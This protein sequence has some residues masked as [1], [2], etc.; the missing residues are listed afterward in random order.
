[1][2]VWLAGLLALAA[3]SVPAWAQD[4]KDKIAADIVPEAIWDGRKIA[5]FKA[6][7]NPPMV[8]ASE[9]DFLDDDEYVLGV[10]VGKESRA[11]PTRFTWWHHFINDQI[12]DT[13]Y[14]VS[15]CSVCNTGIRFDRR[16]NGKTLLFDFYGLYNGVVIMC[17]RE[18][19]SVFLQVA[20]RAIKGPM[21]GTTLKTQPL[22]DTTW[23]EWKKLHPNTLVMTPENDFKKFY[24]D[25][26]MGNEPRG[27]ARFPAP[28]F[29]PTMTRGDKRIP[30]FDKV[31][32]VH[33]SDTSQGKDPAK[34]V[35]R[36]YP[37]KTLQ[38][39]GGVLTDDAEGK[40]VVVFFDPF[41]VSAAAFERKLDGKPLTFEARPFGD[42]IGWFD[43]ET[44]SRWTVEGDAVEGPLAGKRL[45][46]LESH[47]S[48]WYGWAAYF[49]KTSIY[50]RNDAAQ[51]GN[52]FDDK[53][54][55]QGK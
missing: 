35:S 52:P 4:G 44:G 7:D 20:G 10:T 54:L 45:P 21:T 5:P 40:Q 48:Q 28:F 50:G 15:Y 42:G 26:G 12:G 38:I 33:L 46:V 8:K 3:V 34:T 37:I 22:L 30:P 53:D 16:V 2:K 24:R 29:R 19:E 39:A 31:L 51:P 23:K 36:A 9:A 47:L 43:K 55:P 27:H 13:P 25:K 6:I 17:E 14:L 41:T 49:P 1:M 32:G 11:Y 18:T